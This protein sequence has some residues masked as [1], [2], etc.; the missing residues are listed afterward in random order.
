MRPELL[1][2]IDIGTY[3]SKAVLATPGGEIL[4]SAVAQHDLELPRPGW[5][6]HDADGLWWADTVA[7]CR[8]LLDGRPYGGADV[9][10]VAISAIGPCLLPL[11]A[12]DRPL[13]KGILYG[14][15][16]RASEEIE[17]LNRRWGEEAI[18]AFSRMHLSSQAIGPKILW[19]RR[20]EPE[21][22][23]RTAR[24]TTASSYV[25]LR[26]TGEQV[27]DHHT[28]SH[29]MPL[30]GP[31]TGRWS[32]RFAE[33]LA[34][35]SLLPR[36]G[37]SDEMA[38]GVTG[39]AAE[40]TGLRQGT[41]VTVGTVDALSEA[42]SVGVL[43]P[44]ELMVMYGSTTFFILVTEGARPSP[45]GWSTPGAFAG[46]Q[47]L[48]AG[49]ATSGSLTRWFVDE[50]AKELPLEQAY[51]RLSQEAEEVGP[52]AGGLVMLPYFSGERTPIQDPLA[53]GVIAGLSLHH[54]RAHLYR[55][56]LEGVAFGIR[57]NLEAF[58][59]MGE[60]L[61]R[62]VAVGGGAS[63]DTWLRIVSDASG[64]PQEVPR[65][66][67]GASYGD[68]FLAGMATGLLRRD[69]LRDWVGGAR[70]IEPDAAPRAV[71]DQAYERFR[72]LYQATK[73]IVHGLA[74]SGGGTKA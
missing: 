16:T 57:H 32:E 65:T 26:L 7:L 20:H 25:V 71:Y 29:F 74:R 19:L 70:R 11:D 4:R 46:Q 48:A 15:D 22:W 38:G 13:R 27:I 47:L 66:T 63:G 1:L 30:Y 52:G 8:Q 10:A 72:A 69:D 18:Y 68:A 35:L 39:S 55:A 23:E 61:R 24:L 14:V 44:G 51:E 12:Q 56:V 33:G 64:V 49:M 62:V 59:E 43:D 21:V 31:A 45:T 2:G 3:S 5:A 37:W 42:L 17:Q 54:R 9:A 40:A 41:P 58:A 60:T 34:E 50:L 67:V 6:E 28:A 53:R 36:L 73:P